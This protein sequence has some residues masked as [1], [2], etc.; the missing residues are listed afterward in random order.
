[1]LNSLTLRI[2]RTDSTVGGTLYVI[3]V[4]F[5]LVGEAQL[6]QR[7]LKINTVENQKWD[8]KANSAD[9]RALSTKGQ[10]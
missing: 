2:L 8:S 3:K 9:E 6:P 5:Q 7:T 10:D 1:M 4:K